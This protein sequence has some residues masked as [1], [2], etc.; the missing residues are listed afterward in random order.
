VVLPLSAAGCAAGC[1][2]EPSLVP[3]VAGAAA[4]PQ[5]LN[6]NAKINTASIQIRPRIAFLLH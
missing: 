5:A 1:P 2:A 6:S 4:P 3:V